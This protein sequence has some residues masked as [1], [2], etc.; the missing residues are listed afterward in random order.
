MSLTNSTGSMRSTE[1]HSAS[2]LEA[3]IS[4]GREV[5]Q[6]EA[7][8]V[9]ALI[10]RLGLPFGE[11]CGRLLACNGRVIVCGVGKSGHIGTK[12]AATFASTGTPAFFVHA[13]EAS[14]GDLGMLRSEDIVLALSYSGTSDELIAILPG[15]Q[16]LGAGLIAMTGNPASALALAADVH[17]DVA[18]DH[19]ACPLG[20]APT[21]S[22][23][24]MLAMGDALA[25]A[26]LRARG[27]SEE[28]FARSHP[29]GRLGK[30][31]LMRVA[32][33]MTLGD[34][35][36]AV[37]ADSSLSTGLME[38]SRKG[39]GMVLV[40]DQARRLEGIFTD[41]DLR[42]AIEAGADLREVEIRD[43]MTRGP[44]TIE[45]CRLAI[46]AVNTMQSR[47]ITTLPVVTDGHVQGVISMHALLAAGVV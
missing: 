18:V 5:I 16:R 44:H 36:P 10:A 29:G 42:R 34:A 26:L 37:T 19:E 7:D 11:A 17:L 22:T 8:A 25:I 33:V 32:D 30:R 31:L 20:L 24:A 40:M 28:D 6:T 23:S 45:A 14:H 4:S 35:I 41:G 2:D 38:I 9:S 43:V 1:A 12:L 3:F 39:L 21:A 13:A 46:D 47:K 15:L 27:F